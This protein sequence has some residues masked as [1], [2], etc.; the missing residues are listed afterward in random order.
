M[1]EE[2][3]PRHILA[4]NQSPEVLELFKALLEDE[5]YR[6]TVR[7]VV[8]KDLAAIQALA[9][10][11]IVLDYMWDDEDSG[12]S[13]LQLLKMHPATQAIPVIVCTGAVDRVEA[14]KPH[15]DRMGVRVV[16]KPFNL[17]DLLDAIAI[18]IALDVAETALAET[19]QG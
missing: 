10:D 17:E 14:L 8:D 13:F 15:L 18:A 12:W 19:D 7:P 11:L 16:L 3:Q 2:L 6:I 4:I 9:P 1:R 5:G